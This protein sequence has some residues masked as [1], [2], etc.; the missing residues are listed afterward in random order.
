MSETAESGHLSPKSTFKGYLNIENFKHTAKQ[1]TGA[2]DS[3]ASSAA[4]K[5]KADAFLD[6]DE[7]KTDSISRASSKR[8]PSTTKKPKPRASSGYEPPS[9]FAHLPANPL[10]DALGPNSLV[11]FCGLNPGIKT[12]ETGHAYSHPT[13]RFWETMHTSGVLPIRCTPQEDGT[14]PARFQLSLTNIVERP[15]R[16]G[17]QLSNAEKDAGVPVLENKV[18]RWRPEVVCLVGKGIWESVWRVHHGGQPIGRAF[19]EAFEYG[20]QDESENIGVGEVGEDEKV[21]GVVY[22]AGWKGARVFVASSTS[23]LAATLPPAEKAR[24]WGELG[25]WVKKR[26]A[27][28][29]DKAVH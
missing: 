1:Y 3:M 13:N 4:K 2:R 6:A 16:N 14:L 24:I 28:N 12:A 19:H 10:Q 21:E 15:S 23:G 8:N 17:A 5:R 22:T 29:E 20:W 7:E 27:E 11:L 25:D 26:R 9:T 18:R